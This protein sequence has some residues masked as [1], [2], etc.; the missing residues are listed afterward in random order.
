MTYNISRLSNLIALEQ[1]PNL[2][3]GGK[4]LRPVGFEKLALPNEKSS[5]TKKYTF[6]QNKLIDLGKEA[7]SKPYAANSQEFRKAFDDMMNAEKQI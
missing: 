2:L 7:Q 5:L 4:Y 1:Y 6:W 3:E